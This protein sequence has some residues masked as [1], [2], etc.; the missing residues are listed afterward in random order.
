MDFIGEHL[1]PGKLGHFFVLLSF[2]ASLAATV[3]YYFST[4]HKEEADKLRWRQLA[5]IFFV[6]EAVSV[7]SIFAIL[8]Y[9]ISNHLFEYKYAWQHS[10]KALE[11]KYLL[12]CFWEGQE[13]SFL[14]WSFWHCILGL[15]VIKKEKQWEAPVMTVVSFMQLCLATM[16]VGFTFFGQ[17]VGSNPFTLLRNE[18]VAPIFSRPDY[19]SLVQDG[20][21]LNPLLQN[22]WMVIHPRYYSLDLPL[23]YSHLLMPLLVYGQR[24]IVAGF[25]LLCLGPYLQLVY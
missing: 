1:F 13:G 10:S 20:N 6:A 11:M 9:I 8:F 16:I 21:D 7:V 25:V 17:K 15:V 3:S 23:Y 24:I 2:V 14:L 4:T 5:R 18:L 12:S 22:Y 19:L